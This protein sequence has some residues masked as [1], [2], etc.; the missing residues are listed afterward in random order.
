MEYL[1]S[2]TNYLTNPLGYEGNLNLSYYQFYTKNGY[3]FDL[4]ESL[5]NTESYSLN[6]NNLIVL[7]SLN[8][9]ANIFD[10]IKLAN[11]AKYSFNTYL[12]FEN[13]YVSIQNNRVVLRDI[14]S[15]P[16]SST[17]SFNLVFSDEL[18]LSSLSANHCFI[19]RINPVTRQFEYIVYNS[20]SQ[21]ISSIPLSS[22]NNANNYSQ[23][24]YTYDTE[25]NYIQLFIDSQGIFTFDTVNSLPVLSAFTNVFEK[26]H[27][28]KLFNKDNIDDA[29]NVKNS[30]VV[31]YGSELDVKTSYDINNNY[32]LTNNYK[33]ELTKNSN[34]ITLKNITN[35]N[36]FNS[37]KKNLIENNYKSYE[38]IFTGERSENGYSN[39]HLSF[40]YDTYEYY[41][42]PDNLTYFNMPSNLKNYTSLN[43][44]DSN[45]KYNGAIGGNIP[46]NSDKVY[47]K[48]FKY[49]K[50]S[51][52]GD[53][54][55]FDNGSYL[56]TWLYQNPYDDSQ[57][58]WL[59]RFFNPNEITKL[60]ALSSSA[61]S[62]LTSFSN[63]GEDFNDYISTV[64][65]YISALSSNIG[66]ID[67]VSHLSFEQDALYAYQHIGKDYSK[68][69]SQTLSSYILLD[70]FNSDFDVE[71]IT[72]D[73]HKK[74]IIND[75]F[76]ENTVKLDNNISGFSCYFEFGNESLD[77]IVGEQLL[78]NYSNAEGFGLFKDI[79]YSPFFYVADEK[80]LR[81]F[82]TSFDNIQ[83]IS[84]DTIV[85]SA[86]NIK[87]IIYT[88][89]LDNYFV[90]DENNLLY[91]F[92]LDNVIQNVQKLS[93]Y[94]ILDGYVSDEYIH[95]LTDNNT[96]FKYN[97]Y[98]NDFSSLSAVNSG[99]KIII[100]NGNII[101]LTADK[102]IN[103]N[104]SNYYYSNNNNIFRNTNSSPIL[105][106]SDFVDFE[107]SSDN[108]LYVLLNDSIKKI[109]TFIPNITVSETLNL[110]SF[111]T[112]TLSSLSLYKVIK[113][114]QNEENIFV[115]DSD[116]NNLR[117]HELDRDLTFI[118]TLSSTSQYNSITKVDNTAYS[119]IKENNNSNLKFIFTLDNIFSNEK[120]KIEYNIDK[121]YLDTINNSFCFSLNNTLG[122][123][124]L[125]I[126][127]I[128]RYYTL[129]DV[130]EYYFDNNLLKRN[131]YIGT[132]LYNNN[133]PLQDGIAN[134]NNTYFYNKGYWIK[135]FRLYSQSLNY[136]DIIN[137]IRKNED[138]DVD[139]VLSV[140]IDKRNYIEEI[141]KFFKQNKDIRKS[142]YVNIYI[143]SNNLN[144]IQKAEIEVY[145]KQ[146]F[147]KNMSVNSKI[148][149]IIWQPQ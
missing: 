64:T 141:H 35:A 63:T 140:P 138:N 55:D 7:G 2:A 22:V 13:Y 28:I 89:S 134:Y 26:R 19:K 121:K 73:D 129:F 105:S 85:L 43:I 50:F 83:N 66:Y 23:W 88:D 12:N 130:N 10:A 18:G 56:C 131:F 14:S 54:S 48:L 59:D 71:T 87:K 74:Y 91:E 93:S 79:D 117:L 20:S 139:A 142:E 16:L 120:Q 122:V 49:T 96:Y 27:Y 57:I 60:D 123:V 81:I 53:I 8:N 24:F 61:F 72:Y 146:Y 111:T 36:E 45:L 114:A 108:Q 115:V 29:I 100:N 15:A 76:L 39:I 11:D 84:L 52:T 1:L 148:N 38:T 145:I 34:I 78:G 9:N 102:L 110:S 86:G 149:K 75:N 3:R 40:G 5:K 113:D 32:L 116:S 136:Y 106:S 44:N 70:D 103:D 21:E 118:Q 67:V 124:V 132:S 4:Y 128:P 125:F 144:D 101:T 90:L 107:V 143:R 104:D 99:N 97:I 95:F 109:D 112:Y 6:K 31:E 127:G 47:K 135:D 46:L 65:T 58:V 77:N 41:F 80:I 147:K 133:I 25:N 98:T 69:L 137:I 30:Y 37:L 51:N 119:R 68:V 62:L 94:N 42:Q 33:S 82:N 17:E 92:S 126:N